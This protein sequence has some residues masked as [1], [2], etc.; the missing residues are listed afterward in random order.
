MYKR[1]AAATISAKDILSVERQTLRAK[2]FLVIG[3]VLFGLIFVVQGIF[4]AAER[5]LTMNATTDGDENAALDFVLSQY[6]D[7]LFGDVVNEALTDY[8]IEPLTHMTN[9]QT[10]Y[11]DNNLIS[12]ITPL[13]NLISLTH[14]SLGC[15]HT[16]AG[17]RI[18]D[19]TPLS[20]LTNLE[21]LVLSSN[22]VS[23]LTPLS[24][25]TNLKRL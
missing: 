15:A 16:G 21:E 1:K 22:L 8:D 20:G 13:A 23:D 12:D 11:L 17:N 9:L 5:V 18:R 24:G 6:G 14:L 2:R 3:L 25:L 19:L 7:I 10:L 4:G